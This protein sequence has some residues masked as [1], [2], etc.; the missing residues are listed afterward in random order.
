[1][2]KYSKET[3]ADLA[4]QVLHAIENPQNIYH[5]QAHLTLATLCQAFEMTQEEVMENLRD[6]LPN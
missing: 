2:N 4:E 3:L 1:M 5:P 6:Y